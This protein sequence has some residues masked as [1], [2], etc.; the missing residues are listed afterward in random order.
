LSRIGGVTKIATVGTN[1]IYSAFHDA[2]PYW[3]DVCIG[4]P[5]DA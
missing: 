5:F 3:L 4:L 1:L 2:W